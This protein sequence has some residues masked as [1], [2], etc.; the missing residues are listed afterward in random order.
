MK[1]SV[2]SL[3]S[4]NAHE[5][6]RLMAPLLAFMVLLISTLV[7]MAVTNQSKGDNAAASALFFGALWGC[8]ILA[9]HLFIVHKKWQIQRYRWLLS[10]LDGIGLAFLMTSL[11][12]N[13]STLALYFYMASIFTFC[14]TAGR[15]A[16]YALVITTALFFLI[17]QVQ[18]DDILRNMLVAFSFSISGLVMAE[19]LLRLLD[20]IIVRASRLDIVNEF[21]R[22]IALSIE[23]SQVFTLLNAAI[24]NAMDADTYFVGTLADD[25][26]LHID[27]FYDDG[28][29][30]PPTALRTDGSLS[31][32]VLRN[33]RPLFLPDLR[34]EPELEG[35]SI[36]LIG[37]QRTSLSWMGVPILSPRFSGV[38]AIASYRPNAFDRVDMELLENLAQHAA[39]AMDNAFHH[40][41]VERQSVTDSLTGALNH[42][43]F[44]SALEGL[45]E[46]SEASGSPL[47]LIML[48]VDFFK[49][50]ND[51]YGH[52]FGDIVLQALTKTIRDHVKASD[53]VG[54]WGGE[55]FAVALPQTTSLNALV[56]ARRIQDTMYQ[57]HLE[58]SEK[59]LV[60]APTVSQGLGFF[61][62]EAKDVYSLVDLADRRLY[63]AKARGRNQVEAG[64]QESQETRPVPKRPNTGKLKL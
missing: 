63:L 41:E 22:K 4:I 5:Q 29:Y 39:S 31:G 57:M 25:G 33:K 32:W 49:A 7:A 18:A 12:E 50:Y 16:N 54:R 52:Q 61:P 3:K 58:H 2:P 44:L 55:E 8:F 11:P 28:E 43:A 23:S 46:D 62:L 38:I 56:V 17:L 27:L 48:D 14:I 45:A 30:F 24:E 21:A 36:T 60:P 59:G 20:F 51:S 9:V 47:S 26:L 10:I 19:L 42:G 1:V 64:A 35:V 6:Q 15:E 40:A 53:L 37:K 13:L 34:S